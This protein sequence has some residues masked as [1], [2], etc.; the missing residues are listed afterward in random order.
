MLCKICCLRIRCK[1]M[2]TASNM[3]TVA[4]NCFVTIPGQQ[5]TFCCPLTISIPN[6]SSGDK[7]Y[8]STYDNAVRGKDFFDFIH[9]HFTLPYSFRLL[10]NGNEI[11]PYSIV[12]TSFFKSLVMPYWNDRNGRL[13]S[14]TSADPCRIFGGFV[15]ILILFRLLGGK[16]GF[17][18][19]L[20]GQKGRRRKVTNYDACRDLSG[21]RIRHAKSVER[22]KE[23]LEKERRDDDVVSALTVDNSTIKSDFE[24]FPPASE[25]RLNSQYVHEMQN[26]ELRMR[27]TVKQGLKN[28][29]LREAAVEKKNAL[30]QS[31]SSLHS[32]RNNQS[33]YMFGDVLED[34]DVDDQ[35]PKIVREEK[36]ISEVPSANYFKNEA[37]SA[38][39]L[40]EASEAPLHRSPHYFCDSI[41]AT[42]AVSMTSQDESDLHDDGDKE[43][44]KNVLLLNT[45]IEENID[46][47][48]MAKELDLNQFTTFSQ[49]EQNIHPEVIKAKLGMLGLK[50]G[51]TPA[52]RAAR[53]F[54]LKCTSLENLPRNVLAKG[55]QHEGAEI[56]RKIKIRL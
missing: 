30:Q 21:R 34:E 53:L 51:G 14:S 28:E 5:N 41:E 11:H 25:I 1:N 52:E 39:Q 13:P 31:V 49:L 37:V 33:W 38:K 9:F 56:K 2:C 36:I 45:P 27:D 29:K 17:G 44:C 50:R 47:I 18:A 19:S 12:K 26:R 3:T 48:K 16:G 40:I 55:S 4:F 7:A 6:S 43:V 8:R 46:H 10:I 35:L 23:W 54:M 15:S 24:A 20:K 32:L 42:K 22:L